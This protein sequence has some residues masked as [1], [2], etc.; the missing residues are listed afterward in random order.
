MQG[1]RQQ[2]IGEDDV[3]IH[4]ACKNVFLSLSFSF[5]LKG[6]LSAI[7]EADFVITDS[8]MLKEKYAHL[9]ICVIGHDLRIPCSVYE[10]FSQLHE[11]YSRVNAKQAAIFQK[12]IQAFSANETNRNKEHKNNAY[13]QDITESSLDTH[14]KNVV[15]SSQNAI[16]E[17]IKNQ[18]MQEIMKNTNPALSRQIEQLFNELSQKI[19]DTLNKQ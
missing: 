3:K 16:I 17:K 15:D 19:Y 1:L 18:K 5:Y 14:N 2:S 12:D 7:D 11:F 4:L 10:M 13:M 9:P 8:V 6:H